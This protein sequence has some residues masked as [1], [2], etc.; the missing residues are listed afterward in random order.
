MSEPNNSG[1]PFAPAAEG[2]LDIDAIF[3][4]VSGAAS[5]VNPFE[6]ALAQQAAS[7]PQAPVQTAESIHLNERVPSK[8]LVTQFLS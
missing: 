8:T 5:D 3:G 4:G 2:D 7:T 1:F 6:A